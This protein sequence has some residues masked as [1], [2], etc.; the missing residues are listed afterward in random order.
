MSDRWDF[1]GHLICWQV[2]E[3]SVGRLLAESARRCGD[4][5]QGRCHSLRHAFA[6]LALENGADIRTLQELLGHN[7]VSTTMIC[8]QVM[9]R[10]GVGMRRSYRTPGSGGVVPRALLWAGM[11]CPVGTRVG[12]GGKYEV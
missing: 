1:S 12:G 3:N 10:P 8:T 2:H 11:R 7:D 6:T 4:L 9:N 5:R